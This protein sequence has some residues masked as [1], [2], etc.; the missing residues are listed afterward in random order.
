MKTPVIDCTSH[1]ERLLALASAL[2]RVPRADVY[3][4][5]EAANVQ[6]DKLPEEIAT[7]LDEFN[8]EGNQHGY[9]LLKGLPVEPD[10]ELAP[11]PRSTPTPEDRQLLNMEAMLAIA[12]RRLGLHTAYDQGYGNRRSRTVLH[13]LYPTPQAHPLSGETSTI[14]LEF[15]SDLSHHALQPSYI[16]LAC[17]R[18]DHEGKAATLIGSIRKALPLLSDEVKDHLFDRKL[19][20]PVGIGFRDQI[21]DPNAMTYVKPLYGDR[22]DPYLGYDRSVLTAEDQADKAALEA[23][24]DALDSTA[25]AV[26]L[27]AGDLLVIDNLRTAHARTPFEARWDG[28][29]RWLHRAYVRTSRNGQLTGGERAGDV[30]DFIP[31]R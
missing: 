19:R 24:A 18:G 27:G 2:P 25:E 20:R 8:T 21:E 17:S 12:G 6:A 5:L 10:D 11:T 3:A 15:H 14:Q 23:L 7:A 1:Q 26:H 16:V 31:R 29:D 22:D 13:E 9:L 4:F 30:V 28:K